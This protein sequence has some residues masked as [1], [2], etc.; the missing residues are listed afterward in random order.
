MACEVV[1]A[2]V[3]ATFEKRAPTADALGKLEVDFSPINMFAALDA[4][5][6]WRSYLSAGGSRGRI[7]AD[8]LIAAHAQ[9][10]ADRLLTRDRGFY[11]SH[12]AGLTVLD[13]SHGL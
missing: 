6:A 13:P 10:H 11:R 8:F 2:E 3:G 4:A 9:M 5:T 7:V 1:W 12:F